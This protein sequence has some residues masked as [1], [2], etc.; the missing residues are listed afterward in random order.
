MS[1]H[2]RRFLALAAV[3]T[4]TS[5]AGCEEFDPLV[6][7]LRFHLDTWVGPVPEDD[8]WLVDGR[9]EARLH[10]PDEIDDRDD[11]YVDG[12]SDVT[13]FVVGSD[14]SVLERADLGEYTAGHA[15]ATEEAGGYVIEDSFT[16]ETAD[17]PVELV[18]D[19]A[20]F[21]D[22][23]EAGHQVHRYFLPDE[24]EPGHAGRLATDPWQGRDRACDDESPDVSP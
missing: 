6:Y 17:P 14:G 4:T 15:D 11:S 19:C 16:V 22:L 23:C 13:V 5:L 24:H 3:G 20:E 21:E 1:L 7:W 12:F 8:G 9:V 18:L 10:D 2:R